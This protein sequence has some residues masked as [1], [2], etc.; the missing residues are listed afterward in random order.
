MAS[1]WDTLDP[2]IRAALREHGIEKLYPPQEEALAPILRNQNLVVSIPTASG[3]SLVAYMAILHR[4]LADANPGKALYIVPL[5]ALASEKYEELKQFESLGIR[6]GLATGDY[7]EK[8]EHLARFDVI[9]A[10]SEKMD[11]LLRHRVGWLH[12]VRTII[13]DEVHLINDAGRGPTLEVLLSRFR[14]LNPDAQVV[15][16]S[17]TIKNSKQLADWLGAELVQSEWRPT[18]LKKGI[19]FGRAITFDDGTKR[20]LTHESADMVVDL[21]LDMIA[22]KGQC[23]VFVNTRRSAE[24][25]AKKLAKPVSRALG[26]EEKAL[27]VAL[28]KDVDEG[29]PSL[30]GR[31]LAELVAHGVAFHTAGLSSQQ[32]RMVETQFRSGKI[33]VICATPTLAAGVN[34]PAR[35]VIIRDVWR[36]DANLGN[37]PIPVLEVQQMMGRAGRPRYDP[38]GEAV[39]LAKSDDERETLVRSYLDA[40]PEPIVSKLGSEPALRVHILASIAAGFTPSR[41]LLDKFLDSTFYAHQGETWLIKARLEEVLRFLVDNDFVIEHGDELRPTLFGK[42]TSDLYVDPLSALTLRRALRTAKERGADVSTFAFLHALSSTVDIGSLFLRQKDDWVFQ[43]AAEVEEELLLGPEESGSHEEFLSHVKTA[44]LFEDW[45]DETPMD[46]MEEKYAIGP[47]DLR[48]KVDIGQ[49]LAHAMIELGRLEMFKSQE[50]NDLPLRLEAGAKKELLPLI[51]LEGIG[52]VRARVL[53]NSGYKTLAALRKARVEEL[54]RL[55]GFAEKIAQNLKRQVG[56]E[57]AAQEPTLE[58]F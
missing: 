46:Q 38:Y 36:Y 43:K 13:A 14:A 9:V 33:K 48:N 57:T 51:Q 17:A 25:V 32:R 3:K 35:R 58:G 49:W 5:R 55:P 21:V 27:L 11:S 22:E 31:H 4:R 7:D 40:E 10:T 15:A 53:W 44:A 20:V 34:T 50:L 39:L 52:R 56:A 45:L 19:L 37:S 41:K 23:I 29:E 8:D 18:P 47:G 28:S 30:A 12:N 2:R 42:R 1:A 6:T 16:L 26:T 24:A 54:A